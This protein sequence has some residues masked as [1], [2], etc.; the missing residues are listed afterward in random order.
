MKNRLC[1]VVTAAVALM[2]IF[3][4]CESPEGPVGPQGPEGEPGITG[5]QGAVGPAGADG[6]VFFAGHGASDEV[7]GV[8]GDWYLDLRSGELYGPKTAGG[9]GD[10]IPLGGPPGENGEEGENGESGSQ[11]PQ[12]S[13]GQFETEG[14]QGS[15]GEDG[16]DDQDGA[17]GRDGSQIYTGSGAPP[18]DLGNPGDFYL[19]TD[20]YILYGT[21]TENGW[22]THVTLQ[23]CAIYSAWLPR[24]A[25][26]DT[27]IDVTN[28][29]IAHFYPVPGL[30]SSIIDE[31]IVLVYMLFSETVWLLPYNSNALGIFSVLDFMV[32]DGPPRIFI[33]RFAADN[34]ATTISPILKFRYVLIP[35]IP[36]VSPGIPA[37]KMSD[38]F[39]AD[40][41]AVARYYGI[42]D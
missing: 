26:R 23:R 40:Y 16:R 2:I 7:L 37:A 6:S 31:G 19:D 24:P 25:T 10:P 35:P 42:P 36:P 18:D 11:G 27:V 15:T 33:T 21:K 39:W 29:T 38:D 4:A 32:K 20:S 13:Q 8:A 1:S 5:L 22:K 30:T 34:S 14:P 17:V 28:L 41:A 9:W 12:G 3:A